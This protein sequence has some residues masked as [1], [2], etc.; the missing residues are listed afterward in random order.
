MSQEERFNTRDRSYS[1]W[2]RRMSTARFVGMEKAQLLALIDLD[3]SLY[4]EYDDDTKE[5]LALMETAI[6]CGQAVKPATVTR[7][8]ARRANLP[9]FVVLYK[10]AD[11]PN[12]ADRTCRD[13]ESFRVKRLHPPNGNWKTFAPDKW[14]EYLLQIRILAAQSVDSSLF[15]K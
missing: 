2:H 12:P 1:A 3:V 11:Q 13:I 8:L 4:V 10:L 6:D 5:P 7:N 9:A 14:A 15:G